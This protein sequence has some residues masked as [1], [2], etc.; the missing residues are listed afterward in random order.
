LAAAMLLVLAAVSAFTGA[1]T[2]VL[3]MK[4]CPVVKS[5]VALA[6]FLSTIV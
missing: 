1:R 3:P 4:L 5:S 2:S 6:F